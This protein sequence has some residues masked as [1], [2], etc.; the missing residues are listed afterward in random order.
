MLVKSLTTIILFA[1]VCFGACYIIVLYKFDVL[2]LSLLVV[3]E[4]AGVFVF[5]YL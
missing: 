5:D 1:F 4:A 2:L 3:V